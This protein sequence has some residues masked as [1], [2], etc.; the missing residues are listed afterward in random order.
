MAMGYDTVD[1]KWVLLMGIITVVGCPVALLEWR[2]KQREAR[3]ET[4]IVRVERVLNN[5][6]EHSHIDLI[7]VT[8]DGSTRRDMRSRKRDIL[9]KEGRCYKV[10]FYPPYRGISDIKSSTQTNCP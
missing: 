1:A 10:A 7:F 2:D 3:V 8:D 9:L 5:Q 6:V 4:A